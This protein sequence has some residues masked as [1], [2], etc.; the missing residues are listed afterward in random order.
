MKVWTIT[1]WWPE[2]QKKILKI[3]EMLEEHAEFLPRFGSEVNRFRVAG[4]LTTIYFIRKLTVIIGKYKST[5]NIE[6]T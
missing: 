1:T 6:L 3:L 5:K 2:R 4:W